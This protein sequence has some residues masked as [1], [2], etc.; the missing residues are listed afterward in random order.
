MKSKVVQMPVDGM[1]AAV[2]RP[3][4]QSRWQLCYQ[5][6]SSSVRAKGAS[7]ARPGFFFEMSGPL[8]EGPSRQHL[9]I[10]ALRV[11]TDAVILTKRI[12]SA[13]NGR[14]HH[15]RAGILSGSLDP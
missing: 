8:L 13:N 3:S 2:K 9:L 1:I 14:R 12:T 6:T 7:E 5:A 11:L 4:T 10:V 15:E